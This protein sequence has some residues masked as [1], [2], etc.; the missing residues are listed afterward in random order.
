MS[1]SS[2][3]GTQLVDLYYKCEQELLCDLFALKMETVRISE[4][5]AIKPTLHRVI[6]L[7]RRK[8]SIELL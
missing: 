4:M 3:L 5:S 8:L 6:T 2:N 7:K 1:P